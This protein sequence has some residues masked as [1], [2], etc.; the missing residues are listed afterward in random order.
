MEYVL[1][2]TVDFH[3]RHYYWN[4]FIRQ[5][6]DAGVGSVQRESNVNRIRSPFIY[7]SIYIECVARKKIPTLYSAQRII[8]SLRENSGNYCAFLCKFAVLRT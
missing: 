2:I 8:S 1:N 6:W 4:L 5:P 7:Y 3:H